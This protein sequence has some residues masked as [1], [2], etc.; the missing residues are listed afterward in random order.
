MGFQQIKSISVTQDIIVDII[1]VVRNTFIGP[2]VGVTIVTLAAIGFFCNP[3]LFAVCTSTF[4]KLCKERVQWHVEEWSVRGSRPQS[5]KIMFLGSRVRLVRKADNFTAI[6]VQHRNTRTLP[7][8]GSAHDN[9]RTMVHNVPNTVIRE[10]LQMPKAKHEIS[11]YRYHY[12]KRLSVHPKELILNLQEPPETR[13][14]R[15]NLPIGL[16]TRF[17]M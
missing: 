16:P 6:H 1:P 2:S 8:E 10:D 14:L 13:R 5:R 12:S 17:N 3:I 4:S 11:R 15:E 9:G 7:V